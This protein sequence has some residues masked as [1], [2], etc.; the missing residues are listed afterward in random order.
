MVGGYDEF[1]DRSFPYYLGGTSLQRWHEEVLRNAM[2]KQG[3]KVYENEWW[4]F[5]YRDWK[6]YPIHNVTFEK[7]GKP[8]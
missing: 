4:H 3:F 1:S 5:D 7:L 6:K 8:Q 2:E